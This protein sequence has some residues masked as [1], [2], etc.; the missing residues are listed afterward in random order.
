MK[1]LGPIVVTLAVVMASPTASQAQGRENAQGR[2]N[3]QHGQANGVV[4]RGHPNRVTVPEPSTLTLLAASG[5]AFA[6]RRIWNRRPSQA[7]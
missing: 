3:S 5:G 2:G 1:T 4:G 7:R 6:I